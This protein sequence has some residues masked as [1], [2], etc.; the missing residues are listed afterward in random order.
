M[1]EQPEH[2]PFLKSL[3]P[4]PTLHKVGGGFQF[5]AIV[6]YFLLGVLAG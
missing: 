2:D 4:P 1:N 6:R 3:K 5:A